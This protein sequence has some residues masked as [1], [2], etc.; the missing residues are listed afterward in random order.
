MEMR[1]C[2]PCDHHGNATCPATEQVCLEHVLQRFQREAVRGACDTGR[3]RC[4]YYTWGMGPPLVFV[5][6]LVDDSRSYVLPI[7]LLAD[8]F[9]CIAYDLPTG[10]GD[11]ARL[12]H[13]RHA[14]LVEDLFALLDHLG[15][16]RGYIH[17][18]SFGSTITLAAMHTRPERVP[19]AILQGGFARRPLAFA[20]VSLARMARYWPGSMR[21]L[22]F[23][24][25]ALRHSH[26]AP[27]AARDPNVWQF[28]VTSTRAF[29]LSAVA[30]RALLLH[31]VDLRPM[32]AEIRQPVLLIC[33]DADPLVRPWCEEELLRGLPNASRV[34]LSNCGHFP[35]YTH[36]ELMAELVRRFLTPPETN[37]SA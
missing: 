25:T 33:G 16:A 10:R 27:F 3:Y 11:G 20:E 26:Y 21:H 30:Y 5:P 19:R 29:P 31:R 37:P 8:H 7:A 15:V 18:S 9:R 23:R 17:G 24:A 13:Y 1:E 36:P 4:S 6:G 32:L 22:P 2:G 34:E 35:Y 12:R 28:Y 14:D